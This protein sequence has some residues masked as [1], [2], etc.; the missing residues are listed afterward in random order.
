MTHEDHAGLDEQCVSLAS[1]PFVDVDAVAPTA[2]QKIDAV[3]IPTHRAGSRV[4]E[5]VA[6]AASAAHDTWLLP[7]R[8]ALEMA[9][10]LN[11]IPGLHVTFDLPIADLQEWF[12]SLPSSRN[13]SVAYQRD[14]DLP[15][16]RNV[17]LHLSRL[18]GYER[19]CLLD[20][21]IDISATQIRAGAAAL[22]VTVPVA[23]FRVFAFPDVSTTEHIHRLVLK[24]PATTMPGGNC[25][26]LLTSAIQGWFPYAYNDD[27]LFILFNTIRTPGA[28][29][30]T[31]C[32]DA[33]EPWND[34]TRVRFEEFGE[35]IV[36]GLW[37]FLPSLLNAQAILTKAHWQAVLADRQHWLADLASRS[38]D[39]H[40]TAALAAARDVSSHLTAD[41]CLTFVS[42]LQLT[43]KEQLW[44][45]GIPRHR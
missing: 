38:S 23:G 42:V 44:I 15:L 40:F 3:F 32:Q 10:E 19:I 26:F 35:T 45:P 13:P 2:D 4:R 36:R 29:L 28:A 31:V 11:D 9:T 39:P 8:D 16:K 30:G 20:D 34:L 12:L 43:M 14:Y 41:E 5:R 33:H 21:D 25:L 6:A 18:F 27:W 17:A 37:P 24:Q 7:S 1:A 22:S